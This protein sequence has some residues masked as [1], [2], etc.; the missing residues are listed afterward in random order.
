MNILCWNC[1]GMGNPCT[2]RQLRRWNSS[3]TPD[4]M[5][6]SETMIKKEIAEQAKDRIDFSN[7]FG[8]SS[9]GRSGGLCLY[10]KNDRVD[11]S[12]VSFSQHHM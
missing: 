2:V 10:W 8:V 7:A 3:N 9:V 1:R 6:V 11:F 5:F 4:M 12:L